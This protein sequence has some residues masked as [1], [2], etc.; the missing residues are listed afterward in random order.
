MRILFPQKT[1]N[2]LAWYKYAHG[3]KQIVPCK[4]CKWLLIAQQAF[5]KL[6]SF[7]FFLIP[8]PTYY[9]LLPFFF[10]GG[11]TSY[12]I[13]KKGELDRVSILNRRL[14]GKSGVTFFQGG[15]GAEVFSLKNKLTSDIFNDKKLY[16][17]TKNFN[18]EILT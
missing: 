17:T 9:A 10:A 6:L 1:H 7:F 16:K 12:Q 13:F 3:A 5:S 11:W 18:R 15:K 4:S 14:L 2:T 8:F